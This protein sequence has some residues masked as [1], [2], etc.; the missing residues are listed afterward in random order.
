MYVHVH[1]HVHVARRLGAK[2]PSGRLAHAR[3]RPVTPRGAA[4][5]HA[6]PPLARGVLLVLLLRGRRRAGG[7]HVQDGLRLRLRL[8]CGGEV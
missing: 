1:V 8:R 6:R 5:A 2:R 3:H 4:R 7:A